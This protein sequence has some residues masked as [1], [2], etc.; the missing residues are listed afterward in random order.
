MPVRGR[1][2]LDNFSSNKLVLDPI[3]VLVERLG[4]GEVLFG[5]QDCRGRHAFILASYWAGPVKSDRRSNRPAQK[6]R[7]QR[8]FDL[9]IALQRA[10]RFAGVDHR[11]TSSNG[12]GAS[13]SSPDINSSRIRLP[14]GSNSSGNARYSSDVIGA[15]ASMR[16]YY[17]PQQ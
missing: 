16:M 13:T 6:I 12:G 8:I 11:R 1:G 2:H 4:Q 7:K 5:G 9:P 15:R 10:N 14:F 3:A 17:T